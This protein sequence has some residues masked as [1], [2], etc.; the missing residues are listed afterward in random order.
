MTDERAERSLTDVVAVETVAP[1][2]VN[3]VTWSDAY[4]VDARDAGCNCPDKQYQEPPMCKH[5]YAALVSDTDTLPTPFTV[6]DNLNERVAAD[7]GERPDDCDCTERMAAEDL[8]CFHCFA[9][10]FDTPATAE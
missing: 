2:M 4:V 3:V 1:G 5:E 9:A 10:G 8:P 6:T 7:G